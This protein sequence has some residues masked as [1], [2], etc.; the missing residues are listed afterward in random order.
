MPD[1]I[2]EWLP[3]DATQPKRRRAELVCV[4][5]HEKKV[6]CDLQ[7]RTSEGH[8]SCTNC[9]ISDKDCHLRPSKRTKRRR[10]RH[11]NKDGPTPSATSAFGDEAI[12]SNAHAIMDN[13]EV[14]SADFDEIT[15][16]TPLAPTQPRGH[17][18]HSDHRLPE[19]CL[20][21]HSSA[22]VRFHEGL[23]VSSPTQRSPSSDTRTEGLA[24][25]HTGDI[26]TGFLQVYAPENQFNAEKQALEACLEQRYNFSSAHEQDLQESFAE[27]YWEYCYS[28]CPVLDPETLASDIARLPLLANALATASSNVQPPLVPHEGPA[29]YYKKARTIFYEDEE[30][31][32]LTTLM[33]L[34]LFY[35]F[36]PKPPSTVHRHSSWWWTSV[37]IRHAQQMNLHREPVAEHIPGSNLKLGLRRRIWWTAFEPSLS[38]FPSDPIHQRKGE[39]FIYCVR[40]CVIIGKVAKTLSR[41]TIPK[42]T[43]ATQDQH[44]QELVDWVNSLPSHLRLPIG[45]THTHKFDRDVHQ[46][47]LP[48]LTTVIVLHLKRSANTLPE[49]LPPAILAASCIARILRDILSRGNTRF[50]MAITCW[51]CGTAFI[52]LLQACRVRRLA[53]DANECLDILERAADQLQ[54]MWGSASVIR[55]GFERLRSMANTPVRAGDTLDPPSTTKHARNDA[56]RLSRDEYDSFD[57]MALFPF[58]TR[59]T[60]GIADCLLTGKEHGTAVGVCSSHDVVMFHETLTNQ[61]G[62]LFESFMD[63]RLDFMVPG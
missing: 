55:Q 43:T 6:K 34:S 10:S 29:E 4:I 15:P 53:H 41:S 9:N 22:N 12:T 31:D 48:Y 20:G 35:W 45:S 28:W 39:I 30:S 44:R 46:L 50:L 18:Q 40:L 21:R 56:E 14:S 1:I 24:E 3:F 63:Y 8:Q 36:A 59:D 33:A 17:S 51:Y 25:S 62:D 60:G 38:D 49:A 58:A 54:L 7:A 11:Q 23:A 27:T 61:F 47:Y 5:C 42:A 37:I 32:G 52:P 13:I 16:P 2:S 26:D 57:W 19:P